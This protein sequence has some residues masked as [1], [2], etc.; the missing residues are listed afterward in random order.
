MAN[1][2]VSILDD[3]GCDAAHVLGHAL[4]GLI[5]LELARRH[6]ARIASLVLVNAWARIDPHK[7]KPIGR[8]QTGYG[9]PTP[10]C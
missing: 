1:D 9:V 4:G 5:G 3:A 10:D 2:V 7:A 8:N 6:P